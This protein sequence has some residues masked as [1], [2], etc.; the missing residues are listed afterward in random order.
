M[1]KTMKKVV[2]NKCY[3]GFGLSDLAYR[4]LI[5][6]GIPVRRYEEEPFNSETNRYEKVPNNEGEIIFDRKLTSPKGKF[7]ISAI[8]GRYWETWLRDSREHP[9]LIRVVEEL[10]EK[11]NDDCAELVVVKIP[12]DIDYTIEE[13]DGFE[14]IA[15]IHR[16]WG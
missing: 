9:L 16:T 5:K 14:H 2:I 11:A 12:E 15:E 13:Y 6:W 1:S 3:G 8:E 7:A 4:K 10:G